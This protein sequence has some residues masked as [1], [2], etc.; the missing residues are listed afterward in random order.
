VLPVRANTEQGTDEGKANR[1]AQ[2]D[3][4]VCVLLDLLLSLL[5]LGCGIILDLLC[6]VLDLLLALDALGLRVGLYGLRLVVGGYGGDVGAVDIDKGRD[7]VIG[8]RDLGRG[9]S[10]AV[11]NR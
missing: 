1:V 7:A 9:R 2:D 4:V 11:S 6:G 3:R 8:V 5:L 10:A